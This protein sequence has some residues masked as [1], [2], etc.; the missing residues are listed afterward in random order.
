MYSNIRRKNSCFLKTLVH[1]GL[2]KIASLHWAH[3]VVCICECFHALTVGTVVSHLC[4]VSQLE[5]RTIFAHKVVVSIF[6]FLSFPALIRLMQRPFQWAENSRNPL[7]VG[8]IFVWCW[9]DYIIVNYKQMHF[10]VGIKSCS[11]FLLLRCV[12]VCVIIERTK[13]RK[14]TRWASWLEWSMKLKVCAGVSF[15]H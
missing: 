5:G 10:V 2:M 1:W 8:C 13:L 15:K 11:L 4:F 7:W 9:S 12:I 14:G 6:S 3:T